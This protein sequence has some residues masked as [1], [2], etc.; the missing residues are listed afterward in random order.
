MEKRKESVMKDVARV[1]ERR[2]GKRIGVLKERDD[3]GKERRTG[4]GLGWSTELEYA[5]EAWLKRK[6][7]RREKK[8]N[9]GGKKG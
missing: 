9:E 8:G 2:I 5:K 1:W 4:V 6:E 3:R 7:K